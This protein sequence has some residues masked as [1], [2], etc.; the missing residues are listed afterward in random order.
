M[1]YGRIKL[2]SK[3]NSETIYTNNRIRE[4]CDRLFVY[5]LS[6]P[7]RLRLKLYLISPDM[8]SVGN[9]SFKYNP[10]TYTEKIQ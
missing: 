7:T 2:T 5:F 8:K 1:K 4:N 9:P 6:L 10:E 3:V